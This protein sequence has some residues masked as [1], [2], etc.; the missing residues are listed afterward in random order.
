V[1]GPLSSMPLP[2]GSRKVNGRALAFGTVAQGLRTA[3]DVSHRQMSGDRRG[4]ERFDPKAQV[5]EVGSPTRRPA[6]RPGLVCR[7]DVDQRIPSAKLRQYPLP[8][9]EAQAEDIEIEPLELWSHAARRDQVRAWVATIQ[10]PSDPNRRRRGALPAGGLSGLQ[11]AAS[12][13]GLPMTLKSWLPRSRRKE[14][15]MAAMLSNGG[16]DYQMFREAVG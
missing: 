12:I 1:G 7:H 16:L 5:I 2:S 8:L 13:A 9:F 3:G 11:D 14:A 4:V 6:R 15:P 10:D